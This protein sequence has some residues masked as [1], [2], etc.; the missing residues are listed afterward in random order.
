VGVS[1]VYRYY[2]PTTGDFLTVDPMVAETQQPYYYAGDDPV[3][4]SDPTG[5]ATSG[6]HGTS[7]VAGSPCARTA[8]GTT[9]VETLAGIADILSYY[10]TGVD[11]YS[12]QELGGFL[13][14]A[15]ITNAQIFA[16]ASGMSGN[17]LQ[18]ECLINGVSGCL[19]A[20]DPSPNPWWATP[21]GA[22]GVALGLI[23]VATAGVSLEV[24]GGA[25]VIWAGVSALAGAGSAE[26]D[27]GPCLKDHE[28]I[29][30]GG[31]ILDTGGAAAGIA[32]VALDSTAVVVGGLLVATTGSSLDLVGQMVGHTTVA[33]RSVE[34]PGYRPSFT[35]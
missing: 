21:A 2:D 5:R 31:L 6:K 23:A 30:C 20:I 15:A 18:W 24:E 1:G 28:A 13:Y 8:L 12:Q 3:N 32:G 26:L 9:K 14:E 7:S 29:A 34:D 4:N 10:P 16:A 22:A 25:A 27:Q 35:G 19:G 17:Q 33:E 11:G